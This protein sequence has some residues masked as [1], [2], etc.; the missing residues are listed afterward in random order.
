MQYVLPNGN[1]NDQTIG[2]RITMIKWSSQKFQEEGK[3]R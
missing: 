3:V 2:L 1:L